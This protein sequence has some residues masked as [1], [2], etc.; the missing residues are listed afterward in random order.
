MTSKPTQHSVAIATAIRTSINGTIDTL[1]DSLGVQSE[2][3]EHAF[4]NEL[5]H[6]DDTYT[7]QENDDTALELV[8]RFDK[9]YAK[10]MASIQAATERLI[11]ARAHL[12]RI[13][14]TIEY[15]PAFSK[16]GPGYIAADGTVDTDQM[17]VMADNFIVA[18]SDFKPGTFQI[19][20]NPVKVSQWSEGEKPGHQVFSPS[21]YKL[22]PITSDKHHPVSWVAIQDIIN[23]HWPFSEYVRETNLE[24]SIIISSYWQ[25]P[26]SKIDARA[27]ANLA[28]DGKGNWTFEITELS[29]KVGGEKIDYQPVE[30]E[31]DDKIILSISPYDCF[32]PASTTKE[33]DHE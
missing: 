26:A 12:A 33:N 17:V 20:P 16:D 30:M 15:H 19:E 5:A 13:T 21:V 18:G 6:L 31:T 10:T 32:A 24:K 14:N 7:D 1:L 28:I 22:G 3:L 25:C 9:G 23:G 29:A 4:M 11:E 27:V 8:Q 2:Q